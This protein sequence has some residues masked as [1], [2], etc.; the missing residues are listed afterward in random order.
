MPKKK[1]NIAPD[2]THIAGRKL[3]KNDKTIE[4]SDAE[5]VYDLSLGRISEKPFSEKKASVQKDPKSTKGAG[6]ESQ[7]SENDPNQ[8]E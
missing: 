4:L 7:S 5:A 3:K 8:G 1:Y 2:V 6:D